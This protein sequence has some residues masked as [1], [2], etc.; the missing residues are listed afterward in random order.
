M[1]FGLKNAPMTFQMVMSQVLR[2]LNWKHVLCYIDDI[3]VL[4]A[5]S[6]NI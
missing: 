2:E 1:P 5:I 3:L 4:A 6:E